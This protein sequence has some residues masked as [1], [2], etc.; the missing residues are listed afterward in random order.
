MSCL[1]QDY[2]LP[3]GT[4]GCEVDLA[5]A[6]CAVQRCVTLSPASWASQR[7]LR[8][9]CPHSGLLR[10]RDNLWLRQDLDTHA[11]GRRAA[12]SHLLGLEK[13]RQHVSRGVSRVNLPLLCDF[14]YESWISNN[15]DDLVSWN[16]GFRTGSII[17][18]GIVRVEELFATVVDFCSTLLHIQKHILLVC[19]DEADSP[20]T[21]QP[22]VPF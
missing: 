6:T 4:G 5:P 22:A 16:C 9:S 2:R 1:T 11:R 10:G 15:L 7:L 18:C 8:S 3:P 19:I 12:W 20:T 13:I 21:F 17:P 14:S